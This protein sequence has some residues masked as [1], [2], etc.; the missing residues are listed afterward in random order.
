[1]KITYDPRPRRDFGARSKREARITANRIVW[2][3]IVSYFEGGQPGDDASDNDIPEADVHRLED[4]LRRISTE[5]FR[6]SMVSRRSR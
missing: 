1:M 2:R 4:A 3:L 6:K 5:C